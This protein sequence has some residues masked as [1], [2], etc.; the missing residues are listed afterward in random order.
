M[1]NITPVTLMPGDY[2]V[3]SKGYNQNELNGNSE[4]GTP[5]AMGDVASGAISYATACMYGSEGSGF[6]YP[7]N[8]DGG[9]GNRYLAGTF[10]YTSTSSSP[11]GTATHQAYIATTT[12][13]NQNFGGELGMEFKVNNSNGITI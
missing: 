2:V 7:G 4:G 6:N 3:V 9:P 10:S 8:P 1:K 5:F 13:G 11:T 12:M